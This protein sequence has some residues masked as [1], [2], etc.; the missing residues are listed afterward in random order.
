[1]KLAV[2][3]FAT[4]VGYQTFAQAADPIQTLRNEFE[5]L[6]LQMSEKMTETYQAEYAYNL[7]ARELKVAIAGE[8]RAERDIRRLEEKIAKAKRNL[9][10][11]PKDILVYD[12]AIDENLQVIEEN[13]QQV[14]VL[15]VELE[16]INDDLLPQ[17]DI[18]RQ[19]EYELK[20]L[21]DD[22]K[23][24]K[25]ADDF[26]RMVVEPIRQRVEVLRSNRDRK[27]KEINQLDRSSSRLVA[28]N[29]QLTEWRDF[30]IHRIAELEGDENNPGLIEVWEDQ[31]LPA[32]QVIASTARQ[33]VIDKEANRTAMTNIFDSSTADLE[34]LQRLQEGKRVELYEAHA[35]L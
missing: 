23:K 7:S 20:Q 15:K 2:I 8:R 19:K 11:Y 25:E 12:H 5:E 24:Q 29:E 30:R 18:L 13:N 21:R 26:E 28:K 33:R 31:E 16:E 17:E 22:A 35:E 34:L 10:Q 32:L 3:I 6:T 9:I 1:M 4:L 14:V 27:V